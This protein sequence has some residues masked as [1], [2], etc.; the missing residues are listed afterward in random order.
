MPE[1]IHTP[2]TTGVYGAPLGLVRLINDII[3]EV[4]SADS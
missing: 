4:T 1:P 2:K 3:K